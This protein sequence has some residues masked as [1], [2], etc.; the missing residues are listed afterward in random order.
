VFVESESQKS[1]VIGKG[2]LMIKTIGSEA[3]AEL[4]DIFGLHI[5]LFL[6]VKVH[7]NWRKDPHLLKKLI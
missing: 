7:K 4:K 3:R 6:K 2:G 5:D 1:M